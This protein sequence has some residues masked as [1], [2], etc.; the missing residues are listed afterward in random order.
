MEFIWWKCEKEKGKGRKKKIILNKQIPSL[1]ICTLQRFPALTID[2]SDLCGRKKQTHLIFFLLLW[3]KLWSWPLPWVSIFPFSNFLRVREFPSRTFNHYI[4]FSS[5]HFFNWPPLYISLLWLS[6]SVI[7]IQT[8]SSTFEFGDRINTWPLWT[9]DT[10]FF[11][12]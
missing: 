6:K 12:R 1:L 9:V 10:P 4:N 8:L 2:Q 3:K 5:S 7:L 11:F